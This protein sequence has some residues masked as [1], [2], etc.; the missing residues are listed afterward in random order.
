VELR[1]RRTGFDAESTSDPKSQTVFMS[2]GQENLR[3]EQMDSIVGQLLA[4]STYMSR[5]LVVCNFK[6]S[7]IVCFPFLCLIIV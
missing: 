5:G 3:G 6:G 2:A 4:M 1:K 7:L